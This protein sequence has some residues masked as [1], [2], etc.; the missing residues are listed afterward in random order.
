MFIRRLGSIIAMRQK[1]SAPHRH[2]A[3]LLLILTVDAALAT[4]P[5]V[6]QHLSVDDGLPQN[7]VMAS[8]Q[9]A[10]G[11]MWLATED[12]LVRYDGYELKR[13]ARERGKEQGLA[14][15]FVWDIQQD[16]AGDLWIALKDGG[17]ARWHRQTEKI[18]SIRH[19]PANA[20]SLSSDAIRKL[21]IDRHDRVWIGTVGG[22]LNIL[23]PATGRIERY[24][25]D[26]ARDD[27]L[28]SDVVTSLHEDGNGE[29]W[30][31]T[32]DGL[33]RWLPQ[34]KT[35]RRYQRSSTEPGQLSSNKISSI[36]VDRTGVLWVGTF[37]AGL[38]RLE[39]ERDGFVSYRHDAGRTDT[40]SSDEI[41]AVLE[42]AE[43][44]IWVGTAAGLDLLDR[45]MSRFVRNQS[46]PANPTSLRDN[47]VM[48][49]YQDRGGLLWVGTRAG[50][51]SRWNPR[52]WALGHQR[53]RW[54][55]G[56]YVMAFANDSADRIWV[57]TLGAGLIRFDPRSGEHVT[58]DALTGGKPALP[59]RNVMSLL[60]DRSGNLWIGTR[61]GGLGRLGANRRLITMRHDPADAAS[62]SSDGIMALHEDRAGRI[63]VGTFGGGVNILDP[64]SGRVQ[65]I[66]YDSRSADSLS[67]PRATAIAEDPSG[68]MWIGT[69]AGGLD[70]VSASGE[71]LR[72]FRHDP[73]NASSLSANTVYALHVDE[74]NRV[75]VG[76]ESGGLDEIIG[77]AD[78]PDSIRF[79]NVSKANGLTSDTIYGVQS[80]D[81]GAL[82]LS[83]NAG[84]M[85][86]EPDSNRVTSFHRN[87]GL[88]GE[89]FNFGAHFRAN[90]GR[91][92]FGG[93][94][95]FNHFDPRQL[96][97]NADPPTV[98]LTRVDVLNQPVETAIPYP[99]LKS[100]QLGHRD[101]VVTFQFAALDFST[102]R[103]SRYSYRM[104]GFHDNWVDLGTQNRINYT[105]LDAGSYVLEVR[106]AGANGIWSDTPLRLDLNVRPA[107][108][109]SPWAYVL[110]AIA[111]A[112]LAL[113][114]FYAQRR[115]LRL[116]ADAHQ[117]LEREVE[118]RTAELR[119]RN[120]ELDRLS[121]ATGDFLARMSHEIRTPMNGV[122]GMSELLMRSDLSARQAQLAT[123]IFESAR[124][125]LHIINEILD[126]S[127]AEARKIRLELA[128][129]DLRE[130]LE[131][132]AAAL[133]VQA[134]SKGLELIVSPPQDENCMLVGDALR[135]RQ[136]LLNLIGNAIK[137]TSA[138]EVVVRAALRKQADAGVIAEIAVKDTGIGMSPEAIAQVFEPFTQADETTTRRF[139]GTGLGL[140]ICKELLLL[141]G[142]TIHVEST[143]GVGSTFHVTL[144][145]PSATAGAPV[146]REA[147]RNI[148]AGVVSRSKSLRA[149]ML[150][151]GR[152]WGMI[153][154][155]AGSLSALRHFER[156]G[157]GPDVD[158]LIV[159]ADSLGA[160]LASL[161]SSARK[162]EGPA[163][164]L[165]ATGAT[166][167]N[168][169]LEER[170]GNKAIV[171]KPL[172]HETLYKALSDA[173]RAPT[174]AV[175]RDGY[176]SQAA[177]AV[178]PAAGT[179]A[180]AR[181]DESTALRGHVL[182]VDDN[183]VNCMVAEGL[184][185]EL[186]C[187]TT[188]V[189]TG[190]EAVTRAGTQ[191]F[192]AILMD[193][194][195]P[196]L[197]GIA[198]T[199]LIR[200]SEGA[201]HRTPIIAL[202]ANPA[203]SHRQLCLDAGM[204]AFLGK[205]FTL[206]EMSAALQPWLP[207]VPARAESVAAALIEL[208]NAAAQRELDTS[209]I[210]RIRALDRPGRPSMLPRVVSM[211]ISS[212]EQQ[213]AEIR[214]AIAR[215]DLEQVR[216]IA[217]ALKSS[218][219]NVGASQLA[220]L[221]RELEK[222]CCDGD[223]ERSAGIAAEVER[224]HPLAVVALQQEAQRESA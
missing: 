67:S 203:E 126:L 162:H 141:M 52:S 191:R 47:F 71:V 40:L 172:R 64:G 154:D 74:R 217:H 178:P 10:Q 85:R 78:N 3:S 193:L 133:A 59:D 111:A 169:R 145:L 24:R 160:E 12:G 26:P 56:R 142:G 136:V 20:A 122:V 44:R 128:P 181:S 207:A 73:R 199:A 21:L 28:S 60:R 146:T 62:L 90:D 215:R 89:E 134:E 42:D 5:M 168:E 69:D 16:R 150:R 29:I 116:A 164:L 167:I 4:P 108:W 38:N 157:G 163:L 149:A 192:D 36:A 33:N 224:A 182:I 177:P 93:A 197:D 94:N 13:Y 19:D 166:V 115:K 175:R 155:E 70:L 117:R 14:S 183:A 46:D 49:L 103:K 102:S 2:A 132:S 127:K 219:G 184:L 190:R 195:M 223:A 158:V 87:E 138:G 159:D 83:G 137:F 200:K 114:P 8:L 84:L 7:T 9:D 53:P 213:L 148:R 110:Y 50:G 151:R 22:G 113:S 106:A 129:M 131:E 188:T 104:R 66:A 135:I 109:L 39:N 208:Q 211:F 221:A 153:I 37:D 35:F 156:A 80:D 55:D 92:L 107:P 77:S 65:R 205:P 214:T 165:L 34:S 82:W 118:D 210:T 189:R 1:T 31:G 17:V 130:V 186:G 161:E 27:S 204:D 48:S 120:R 140:S 72:V 58:L 202:S 139:G 174:D 98:A 18:S 170:F 75:W 88:Q 11:F 185:A 123:T 180:P 218:S 220:R 81:T 179:T 43:G 68:R 41:R 212:S 30:V 15:S 198:A 86:F 196:D 143:P 95:G 76:T 209:A 121:R 97:R 61:A 124:G 45:A 171:T 57:G 91:M 79:R 32:D 25:S 101:D 99:L 147:L 216:T 54:L 51:V 201:N 23:E 176:A 152:A 6:L 112:F 144:P 125:L 119:E 194:Y 105:N 206:N 100:L 173:T 222:A 63:W 96:E 187:T